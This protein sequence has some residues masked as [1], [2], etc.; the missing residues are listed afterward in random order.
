MR[1]T[2]TL[3]VFNEVY[4][5]DHKFT[6]DS[7]IHFPGKVP[8]V[9]NFQTTDPEMVLGSVSIIRDDSGLTIDGEVDKNSEVLKAIV[10]K[11]GLGGFY[12]RIDK[13]LGDGVYY[14]IDEASLQYVS[15]VPNPVSP[16]LKFTLED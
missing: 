2:G 3:I 7:I 14:I 15:I 10:D 6:N 13:H 9:W 12:N 5:F 16:N 1:I 11:L 4:Q 8:L